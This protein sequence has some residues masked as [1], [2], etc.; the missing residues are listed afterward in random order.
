VAL[1][2]AIEEFRK[3]FEKTGGELLVNEEPAEALA[4]ADVKPET[5]KRYTP[6]PAETE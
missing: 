3:G 4:E 5:V 6:P 1:R 2:D